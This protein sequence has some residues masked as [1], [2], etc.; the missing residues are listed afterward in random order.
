MIESAVVGTPTET[1]ALTCD[2]VRVLRFGAATHNSHRIHYDNNYARTE[3]LAAPVVMAQLQG[4]L[5][6][7]AAARFAGGYEGVK[8]VTWQNRA[9]AAVGT[10][11]EVSGEVSEIDGEQITLTLREHSDEGVLCA[12]GSAVVVRVC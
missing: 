4:T 10:T 1:L 7:R 2:P 9:P 6:F 12:I 8:S 5:F 3:G 11:L